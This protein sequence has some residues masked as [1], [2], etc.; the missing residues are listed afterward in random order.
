MN[1]I[2]VNICKSIELLR[3]NNLLL[4]AFNLAFSYYFFVAKIFD[5]TLF[6]MVSSILCITAG[7]YVI[8]DYFDIKIDKINK[9]QKKL[10]DHFITKRE[11]LSLYFLLNILGLIFIINV[12]LLLFLI[13][14]T[15]IFLLWLYSFRL[16]KVALIG[17]ITVAILASLP[18]IIMQLYYFPSSNNL[19]FYAYFAF[20]ITLLREIVKDIEDITGDQSEGGNTLPIRLGIPKTIIFLNLISVVYFASI[21][22]L[23]I[24]ILKIDLL[25]IA[26]LSIVFLVFITLLNG[27]KSG[28]NYHLISNIL[29]LFMFLGIITIPFVN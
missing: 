12:S 19:I 28:P 11:A 16:K 27:T 23:F 3:V 10:I 17:N 24:L 15:V 4:L 8:N 1:K 29:K 26:L 22:Y 5:S 7:G 18:L 14:L 21:F 9:P 25:L 6:L 13:F 2:F 20:G